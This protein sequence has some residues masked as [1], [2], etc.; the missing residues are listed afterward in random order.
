MEMCGVDGSVF[1]ESGLDWGLEMSGQCGCKGKVFYPAYYLRCE[2]RR[3][4]S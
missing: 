3:I 4:A 2:S 1:K